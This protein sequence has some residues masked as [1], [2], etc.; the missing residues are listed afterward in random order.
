VYC[1]MRLGVPFIAPRQQGAVEA[2]FGRPL[3]PA[4]RGRT[5]LSDV[6]QTV[7]ST[8]TGHDKESP[9]WL[10]SASMGIRLSG[11][12]HRTVRCACRPLASVDM[13]TSH[14]TTGTPDC[15]VPRVDHPVNYNRRSQKNQR[16]AS[17]AGPCTG[18]SGEWH[19]TIRR[20]VVQHF[21]C[22]FLCLIL[23]LT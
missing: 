9:D 10:V 4:I 17:L 1:S 11:A 2:P 23:D 16:A 21:P 6:H 12:R 3:L 22:F 19:R 18:L 15:L 13:A 20:Y 8:R 14:C 5:G 7:N